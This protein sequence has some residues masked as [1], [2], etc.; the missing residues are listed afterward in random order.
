[1]TLKFPPPGSPSE[2]FLFVWSPS[3]RGL[4]RH[5]FNF[6]LFVVM[7]WVLDKRNNF[8]NG[9]ASQTNRNLSL[10]RIRLGLKSKNLYAY[11]EP[12]QLTTKPISNWKISYIKFLIIFPS[13]YVIFHIS[14]KI[15][16]F[17]YLLFS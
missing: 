5:L 8:I 2:L 12:N 9:M 16:K 7:M 4:P 14:T 3:K 17:L 11:H 10:N 6:P 15:F 13:Q 1:M